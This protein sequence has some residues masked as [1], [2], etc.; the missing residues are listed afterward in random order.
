MHDPNLWSQLNYASTQNPVGL[1]TLKYC[2]PTIGCCLKFEIYLTMGR[3]SKVKPAPP[4]YWVNCKT[5]DKLPKFR[6]Y[7]NISH[8]CIL[9]M[10]Y[11]VHLISTNMKIYLN[12]INIIYHI[13]MAKIFL[14]RENFTN[15]KKQSNI[16]NDN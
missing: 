4:G 15:I 12:I 7:Y 13:S 5:Q 1:D 3:L 9:N 10:Q 2:P 14:C 8:C 11:F 16:I 6:V